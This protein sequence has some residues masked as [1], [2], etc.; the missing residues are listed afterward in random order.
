MRALIDL[1]L[2]RACPCGHPAGPACKQC[3]GQLSESA[4]RLVLPYPAPPGLPA[5]AAA[6]LYRGRVRRLL[7]AYK[8]RGRRDLVPLLS[9]GLVHALLA[10]PAVRSL[11][12]APDDAPGAG[13]QRKQELLLVPVPASRAAWR[14]RG[15]D[16]IATLVRGALAPLRR[17]SAPAGVTVSWAP[18][19]QLTR[20][21]ADQ[22]GLS[23]AG[24][25]TNLSG[26]LRLRPPDRFHPA[27]TRAGSA[28][29]VIL[30]D[31]VLTT[32]A[33]MSEAA[34]ALAA[35]GVRAQCAAVIATAVR[36]HPVGRPALSL[37]GY[38][39]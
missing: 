24:R 17:L 35:G 3:R 20:G 12:D 32:G 36:H 18:L 14:A 6:A 38:S 15:V 34:R 21:V 1:L 4:A 7:I 30:I 37:P 8:E 31:D 33:T 19:L 9:L 22:A 10:L 28:T 16:H 11:L 39:D 13:Q 26:A 25:A 23:A 5:C 29:L 27:H 2:P